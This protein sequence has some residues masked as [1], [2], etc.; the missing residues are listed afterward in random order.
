MAVISAHNI[1]STIF[2]LVMIYAGVK[3]EKKDDGNSI[4]G[5]E[6]SS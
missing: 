6:N 2:H 1:T 3:S 5:I 4:S